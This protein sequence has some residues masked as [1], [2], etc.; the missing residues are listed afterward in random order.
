MGE[1]VELWLSWSRR[2]LQLF[3]NP[4]ENEWSGQLF[5]NPDSANL[6]DYDDILLYH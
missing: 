5:Y 6:R 1:L 3:D 4:D 2:K